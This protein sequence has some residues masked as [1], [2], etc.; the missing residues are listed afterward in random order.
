MYTDEQF[1]SRAE[2]YIDTV[3]RVAFSYMKSRADADDIT[4]NALI[5]LYHS[6]KEFEDDAHVKHW[7]IR[8]TINE[9]KKALL[10]PW[11]RSEPVENYASTLSFETEEHSEIFYAV[12]NLPRKYRVAV[13]LHY[14]EDYSAD[15]ISELLGIPKSTV[16]THLKRGREKLKI[17]LSEADD[18]V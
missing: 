18:Y 17:T 8:V 3:F 12:M 1:T 2:R 4:Q 5:K 9:C 13:F 11:R 6:K 10:S 16:Y 15:E 14:Y 7:L